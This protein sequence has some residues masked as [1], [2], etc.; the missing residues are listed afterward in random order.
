MHEVT[1]LEVQSRMA[2]G[3]MNA[4]SL[5]EYYLDRIE[6]IDRSG[7]A[8]NAVIEINPDALAIAHQR[9]EERA[10]GNVRGPLHGI[11]IL[12]KDN[13]AGRMCYSTDYL[14]LIFPKNQTE[15]ITPN[16]R[17]HPIEAQ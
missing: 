16:V 11:P 5:V 7:P 9:D 17:N 15:R 6:R 3:K 1:I 12:I 10:A 14:S 13:I 4:H 8:I 2:S